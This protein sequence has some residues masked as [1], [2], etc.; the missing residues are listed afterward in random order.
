MC[1]KSTAEVFIMKNDERYVIATWFM[2]TLSKT[3]K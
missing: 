1:L 3:K 2:L